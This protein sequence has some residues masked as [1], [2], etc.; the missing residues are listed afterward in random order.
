MLRKKDRQ[1]TKQVEFISLDELVPENHL[2]RAVDASMDFDFIYDEVREM[3][4]ED[5]G[6]PSIDPVVLIKLLMLQV[7]YGIKSMRQA[8][9]DV[10]V[11]V[12]YRWF[13]DM[14]CRRR[15]PISQHLARTT[16]DGSKRVTCL[17]RFL[18]GY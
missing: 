1:I 11:N 13:W 18:C 17:K 12:A 16:N 15:F 7:L 3:Y 9:R 6:R 14:V 8:I 2:L 10:E 4:S 5:T